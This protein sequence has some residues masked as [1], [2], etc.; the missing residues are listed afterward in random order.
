MVPENPPPGESQCNGR[1]EEAGKTIRSYLR[2]FKDM[3][4]AETQEKLE[5]DAVILQWLVRWMAMMYSR[6]RKGTYGRMA[7]ERQ[8]GRKCLIDMVPFGEWV[9]YRKLDAK[10]K[11]TSW[12]CLGKMVCGW[13]MQERATRS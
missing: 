4:E 6:V 8:E 7:Y 9:H 11:K 12:R 1:A 2:L 13:D 3:I 5:T 10:E